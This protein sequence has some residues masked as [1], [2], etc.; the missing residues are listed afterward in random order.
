MLIGVGL[1]CFFCIVVRIE[2]HVLVKLIS[3]ELT[4]PEPRY[5]NR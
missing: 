3:V 4:S 1:V 5:G 2:G